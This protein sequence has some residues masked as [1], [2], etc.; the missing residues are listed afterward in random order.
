MP[1]SKKYQTISEFMRAPFNQFTDENM[2]KSNKYS[3]A[4]NEFVRKNRIYLAGYTII[5][6][7]YYMH[8]K[9]PSESQKD[10]S[11]Y[12]DVVIRFFSDDP[13][14]LKQSTLAAYNIQFFSNSPGFI[15]RYAVLYKQHGYLI[16]ALQDK[17]D[18]DYKDK[19]PEKT[20]PNMSVSYDKTI[21]FAC[22]YISER[23]FRILSKHGVLLQKKK[24]PDVFFLD[25]ADFRSVKLDRELMK[26]EKDLT[27]EVEKRQ[28]T[29]KKNEDRRRMNNGHRVSAMQATSGIIPASARRAI[30]KVAKKKVTPRRTTRRAK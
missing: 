22:K 17:L 9:V 6:D 2:E 14:V 3:D 18:P 28:L 7:S 8:I 16:D 30:K 11:Y 27:K 26:V 12:Y 5:E 23:R 29:K 20:N 13:E 25:I 19:L 15:Y 24:K 4:Y 1:R 10:Q 21:Y